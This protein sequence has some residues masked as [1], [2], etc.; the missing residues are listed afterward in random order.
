MATAVD[1]SYAIRYQKWIAEGRH[2]S[3][4]YMA[5]HGELRF[6]PGMLLPGAKSLIS[7][8]FPYAPAGGY[9]HP[10]IADYALGQDY[11]TVLR[12]RLESV[13]RFIASQGALSRVCI[14]SAPVAERYWAVRA[15][16]GYQ[17]ISGQLIV[18]GVGSG[19]FLA[20]IITTLELPPSEPCTKHCAGC[21]R[22]V[23]ACPGGAIGADG[24]FDARRCISY[25]TTEHSG[26]MPEGASTHGRAAGC[27]ICR[28][29]C[30]HTPAEPPTP[31]YEFTP[32]PRLLILDAPMLRNITSSQWKRLTAHSA[33]RRIP[34]KRLLHN[35]CP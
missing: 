4:S 10:C 20:E 9:H 5:A 16:V 32:D 30:P 23:K 26:P 27:D 34:F 18:P 2:G 24:S 31:L 22:C 1:T 17:G 14:D 25:L 35:L 29:V 6:D 33:L 12:R 8:A 13:M 3:M 21:M 19:V 15:G 7:I 28:L 11:H